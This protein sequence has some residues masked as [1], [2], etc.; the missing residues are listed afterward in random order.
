MKTD[1]QIQQDVIRELNWDPR[2]DH[3]HID[4]RVENGVVLLNGAVGAYAQK[5]AAQDAAHRV[6]GVLDVVSDIK[7]HTV[8]SKERSDVEIA[9]AVRHAFEWDAS[10]P[11]SQ[12]RST[13]TDG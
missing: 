12:I 13:V 11:S 1:R 4:V 9:Q 2:V 10:V 7:V 6:S 8:G 3:A 5:L